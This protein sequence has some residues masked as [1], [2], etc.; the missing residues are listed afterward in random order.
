M[1][2]SSYFG[3]F[4]YCN[5]LPIDFIKDKR[6][7]TQTRTFIQKSKSLFILLMSFHIPIFGLTLI[8]APYPII[9]SISI[10]KLYQQLIKTYI[11]TFKLLEKNLTK[12][13]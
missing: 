9:A 7:G 13:S 2:L 6:V 1:T 3:Y 8:L 11:I 10:K 5:F 12:T 4:F